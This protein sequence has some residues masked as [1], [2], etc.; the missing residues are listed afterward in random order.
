MGIYLSQQPEVLPAAAHF[1][2]TDKLRQIAMANGIGI[3]GVAAEVYLSAQIH[4]L[5]KAVL[6]GPPMKQ[7]FTLAVSL[8]V[9]DSA[10]G[11]IYSTTQLE[12]KGVGGNEQKAYKNALRQIAAHSPQIQ[13]FV[14]K[15]KKRVVQYYDAN[16]NKVLA[17]A[18]AAAGRKDFAT[19]LRMVLGVPTCCR[20]YLDAL[21]KGKQY[22]QA[23]VDDQCQ[24][25]L[26]LAR[27]AWTAKQNAEGA[28]EA[29]QYLSQI[30]PDAACYDEAMAIYKDIKS[31]VKEDQKFEMK[32]YDD[33]VSLE[34]QRINMMKE[35]G[36]AFG[37]GPKESKK[38]PASIILLK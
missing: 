10:L 31:K 30:Y 3:D 13:Q 14:E 37:K 5:D 20:G 25:S 2:M 22:Y 7:S 19:A 23:F 9:I 21:K 18:D 16:L 4:V 17:K 28:A 11:Q 12:V 26:T 6:P 34:K 8:Y 1:Y 24:R 29:G 27:T 35:V 33:G 32:Q 36:V 15:G 38:D